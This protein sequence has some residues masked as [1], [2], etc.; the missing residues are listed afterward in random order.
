MAD[1]SGK[2][3]RPP[4]KK[5]PTIFFKF[6]FLENKE[7]KI[8]MQVSSLSYILSRYLENKFCYF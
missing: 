6:Y 4:A 1:A 5:G 8:T 7:K 3:N 2:Y